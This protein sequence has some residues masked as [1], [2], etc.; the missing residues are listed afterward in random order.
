LD[1]LHLLFDC[2]FEACEGAAPELIEFSPKRLETVWMDLVDAAITVWPVGDEPSV[3][4]HLEVLRHG[5]PTDR[6]LARQLANGAWATS[7]PSEDRP[8]RAIA[9]RVPTIHC[10]SLH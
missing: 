6:K 9:K 2:L 10:V 5:G 7:K 8:P 1:L 4:K 3:F